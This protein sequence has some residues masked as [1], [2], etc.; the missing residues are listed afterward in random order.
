MIQETSST[1]LFSSH[2]WLFSLILSLL[3]KYG[4]PNF[5]G[6]L[7]RIAALILKWIN[8]TYVNTD[9]LPAVASWTC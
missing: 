1:N 9:N 3:R 2:S 7:H 6:E 4:I 8:S 5:F